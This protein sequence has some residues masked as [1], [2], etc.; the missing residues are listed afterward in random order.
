MCCYG[1]SRNFKWSLLRNAFQVLRCADVHI[2]QTAI[3]KSEMATD[4]VAVLPLSTS[5]FSWKLLHGTELLLCLL[6]YLFS[7]ARYTAFS[8]PLAHHILVCALSCYESGMPLR[9]GTWHLLLR[10]IRSLFSCT[11]LVWLLS[12]LSGLCWA[13]GASVLFSM[14]SER[15]AA[16]IIQNKTWKWKGCAPLTTQNCSLPDSC[17][18][19]LFLGNWMIVSTERIHHIHLLATG[20][21]MSWPRK[22]LTTSQPGG[23]G[24]K[25]I[26]AQLYIAHNRKYRKSPQGIKPTTL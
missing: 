22:M 6:S 26:N 19:I 24:L 12:R 9:A 3:S 13:M 17:P 25:T 15:V 1:C 18:M 10:P 8:V 11:L 5:L 4:D 2:S 16:L 23:E 21:S 14:V 20:T 7:D